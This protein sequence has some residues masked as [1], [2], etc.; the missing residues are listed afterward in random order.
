MNNL[1]LVFDNRY[2]HH[3]IN[4]PSL[5]NPNRLRSVYMHLRQKLM[6]DC[7]THIQPRDALDTEINAVHSPFYIDQLRKHAI[8]EDPF[9]YDKDTYLMDDSLPTARLA[10]GGCFTLADR[11]M[12]GDIDYGFGLIRP[13]GPRKRRLVGV[14]LACYVGISVPVYGYAIAVVVPAPPDVAAV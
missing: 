13:P 10:A 3:S 5:E 4:Q 11:I 9:S 12:E 6:Q 14:G 1:G 8:K 7:F 2:L